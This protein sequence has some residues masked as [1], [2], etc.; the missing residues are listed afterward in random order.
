MSTPASVAG[1]D[2]V[3]RHSSGQLTA[4][5]SSDSALLRLEEQLSDTKK[6]VQSHRRLPTDYFASPLSKDGSIPVVIAPAQFR[7]MHDPTSDYD[8]MAVYGYLR[9]DGDCV[10]LEFLYPNELRLSNPT[11]SV[12]SLPRT[13][14][15]YDYTSEEIYFLESDETVRGPFRDGDYVITGGSP[16]DLV[17]RDC[18][19]QEAFV[20]HGLLSCDNSVRHKLCADLDY[21]RLF[22]TSPL[23]AQRRLNRIPELVVLLS[24][25]R[26]IEANRIAAW[27]IC[28]EPSLGA[29]VFL[30]GE[31]DPRE[32]AQAIAEAHRD[33]HLMVGATDEHRNLMKTLDELAREG[34]AP[35]LITGCE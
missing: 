27:G 22:S 15:R 11:R 9:I 28:H 14:T 25:L 7:I 5:E 24:E 10:Y 31:A 6:A 23:E 35:S 34:D 18:H 12:L 2:P 17:D 8:S 29:R 26:K 1:Q 19:G 16:R 13:R 33:I 30:F 32:D 21:A 3:S 4:G 20:S